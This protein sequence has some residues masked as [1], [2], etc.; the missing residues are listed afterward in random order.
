MA[1]SPRSRSAGSRLRR[2]GW[3]VA[4]VFAAALPAPATARAAAGSAAPVSAY[5]GLSVSQRAS[6]MAVARDTW[7]FY[8][9]D[10]DQATSLPMDNITFA[11]GSATP[12]GY[13]RYTS[14]ANIGVY[15]WAVVAARDL[16]LISE[17][18]AR[19]R[20]TA[21]LTE[22]SHLKRFDGFLYQWYDTTNGKVLTNPGQGD[23]TETNPSAPAFD[24]CFFV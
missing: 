5:G 8:G 9:P 22:V 13:G 24:N 10:V 15:L 2:Y 18:Q 1:R 3:V 12:T 6:L 14:S 23:C 21:T 20:L 4:L 7:K 11:G 19:A 16:G 17:S